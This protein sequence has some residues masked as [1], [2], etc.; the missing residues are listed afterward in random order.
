M[1]DIQQIEKYLIQDPSADIQKTMLGEKEFLLKAL[2][3][4]ELCVE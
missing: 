4:C 1:L 2:Q 3:C